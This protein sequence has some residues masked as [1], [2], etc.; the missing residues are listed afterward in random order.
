MLRCQELSGEN[1]WP[2][3]LLQPRFAEAHVGKLVLLN[4]VIEKLQE[5]E[6]TLGLGI[7]V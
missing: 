1:V 7:S 6:V 4:G 3:L 5:T 2:L